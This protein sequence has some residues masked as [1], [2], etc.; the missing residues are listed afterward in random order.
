[1]TLIEMMIVVLLI[2]LLALAAS[3]FTNAWVQT[4]DKS[5]TLSLLEQAV[6]SAKATALRNKAAVKG[7][8]ASSA[9]CLANNK[10]QLVAALAPDTAINCA[11][12]SANAVLWS[13][14]VSPAIAITQGATATPWTC[15]C[16]T[17]KG[18]LTST[19][20]NCNSCGTTLEFTV[21]IGGAHADDDTRR[22]Y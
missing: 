8:V 11:A 16:F 14:D 4:A 22:I 20:A 6:G 18:L 2:G 21:S 17:N 12:V 19:A 15:S 9:L 1:M 7:D 5:K 3:P 10:L 13:T